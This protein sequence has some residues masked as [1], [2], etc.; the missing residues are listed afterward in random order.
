[1]TT[2]EEAMEVLRDLQR[3]ISPNARVLETSWYQARLMIIEQ[4]LLEQKSK[5]QQEDE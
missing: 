5:E 2:N 1:M 3:Q 4:Y